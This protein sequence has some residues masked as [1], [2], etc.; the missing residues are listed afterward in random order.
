MAK[1]QKKF[2]GVR[3]RRWG[4]WVSEIRH[5]LLKRRVW[6]GTFETAEDAARAYDEAAVLMSGRTAKTNFPLSTVMVRNESRNFSSFSSLSTILNSKLRKGYWKSLP[7]FLTCLRLDTE[8]CRI[9]V[10]QRRTGRYR[11]VDSNWLMMVEL[12][13]KK[14][15]DG[16]QVTT[17]ELLENGVEDDHQVRVSDDG[18]G[19]LDEEERAALQMI[20]ELLNKI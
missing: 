4:S 13:E 8:N 18:A 16:Y 14:N 12:D 20:E 19:S 1:Q 6:L 5:P 10:W 15:D 17:D 7:P 11:V 2:R 9:G 3:Q